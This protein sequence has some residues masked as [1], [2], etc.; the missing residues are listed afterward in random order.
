MVA[1]RMVID[2]KAGKVVQTFETSLKPRD[3]RS[4]GKK[5]L[6]RFQNQGRLARNNDDPAIDIIELDE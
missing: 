3:Y 1:G 4:L 2:R 6:V 5:R